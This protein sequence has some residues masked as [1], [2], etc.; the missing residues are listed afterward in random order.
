MSPIE[1]LLQEHKDIMAQAAD[2]CA[3]VRDLQVRGDAALPNALPVLR[4]FG[5]M[6]QT[7]LARHAQKEDEVLFPAIEAILGAE[8]TPT[9]VMRMEHAE[10]HERGALFRR[11][12]SELQSVEHPA[13]EATG[14]ALRSLTDSAD[15]ANQ[16]RGQAL[17]AKAREIIDLIDAHFSKE[18]QILF[19]MAEQILDPHTLAEAR[20]KME[21][22]A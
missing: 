13:L 20:R 10:I 8:G 22:L 19:P 15:S 17:Q 11:T 2:L 14:G 21:A 12:L 6:M 16:G 1:H 5:Q 7:Q 3:A 9:T 4:R 18:E